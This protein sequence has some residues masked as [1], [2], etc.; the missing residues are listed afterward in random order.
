MNRGRFSQTGQRTGILFTLALLSGTRLLY[1][2]CHRE[3]AKR[4]GEVKLTPS[5]CGVNKDSARHGFLPACERTSCGHHPESG[6]QWASGRFSY[7]HL[8]KEPL[9]Q[10]LPSGR[11]RQEAF[12]ICIFLVSEDLQV[13]TAPGDCQKK[14]PLKKRSLLE[15]QMELGLF[16][17]STTVY[18]ACSEIQNHM[19]ESHYSRPKADR[20][21]L[22]VHS[23]NL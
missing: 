10:T 13:S 11:G 18:S 8:E 20:S 5:R 7:H 21:I 16:G 12:P 6:W 23:Y 22:M 19:I 1:G 3:A 17:L 4:Q 9:L 15:G 2:R 14:N